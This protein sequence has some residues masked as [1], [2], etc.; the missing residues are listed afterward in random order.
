LKHAS[1]NRKARHDGAV[2]V[3]LKKLSSLS[4][5]LEGNVLSTAR[6]LQETLSNFDEKIG[7]SII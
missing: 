3:Y 2:D 6:E 7:T 4:E 5:K 1:E